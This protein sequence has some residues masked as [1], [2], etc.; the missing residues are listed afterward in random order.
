MKVIISEYG[1]TV[2]LEDHNGGQ[3]C[4]NSQDME[5]LLPEEWED[6]DVILI[7][8]SYRKQFNH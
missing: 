6:G 3:I 7:P 4:L 2:C 1:E 8:D 5:N